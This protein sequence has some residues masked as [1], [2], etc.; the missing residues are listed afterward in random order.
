MSN[1]LKELQ[2]LHRNSKKKQQC[3]Y[4][5]ASIMGFLHREANGNGPNAILSVQIGRGR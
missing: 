2:R 3:V 4:F 1:V 5:E